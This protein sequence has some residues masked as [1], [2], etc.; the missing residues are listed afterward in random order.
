MFIFLLGIVNVM[1]AFGCKLIIKSSEEQHLKKFDVIVVGAGTAGCMT[2]KTVADVGLEVCLIDRKKK[3]EIGNKVCG[4]AIGR[5]H[6]NSL[7]L[8]YPSGKEL[9]RTMG[10]GSRF[11][12]LT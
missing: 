6:F 1:K 4:D 12:R 10:L 9:E 8:D 7:S 2:A 11:I 3:E 5:H